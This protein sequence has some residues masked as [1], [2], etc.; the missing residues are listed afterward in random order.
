MRFTSEQQDAITAMRPLVCVSAGAGS[1]KTT[2]LVERI[3]HLLGAPALW[4][5]EEPQLERIAAITF[6][7][8]AAA[9]MK[10]RLR[11]KFRER[12]LQH[13]PAGMR[14]WRE[15]ER[16]VETARIST[17]HS[18]CASLLRE[19]ALHVGMDPDWS[20]LT[21]A[22]SACM[23]EQVIEETLHHLLEYEDP[24][25]SDLAV[26]LGFQ[27]LKRALTD[28][29]AE[30]WK[31]RYAD[32]ERLYDTPETLRAHWER[33][34]PPLHEQY[35]RMFQ[36]ARMIRNHF[37]ALEQYEGCCS[38]PSDKRE[39]QRAAYAALFR[40]LY[41]GADGLAEQ[42]ARV[43]DEFKCM[44]RSKKAWDEESFQG[45]G[46]AIKEARAFLQSE[47][48][49]PERDPDLELRAARLTCEFFRVGRAVA[50]AY[51][52]AR[53]AAAAID[54]DDMIAETQQLLRENEALRVHAARQFR[55]LLIDE[56]QDTDARQLEVA[57]L[58][59]GVDG[60]PDLF[61]VGDAK[62][63]IYLFRGAEVSLFRRELERD[64]KFI[65]LPVNYR[66]LPDV[67]FFVNDFFSKSEL[68][69]AVERYKPMEASRP[70]MNAPRVELFVPGEN[71]PGKR[72]LVEVTNVREAKFIAGRIREMCDP[73]APLLLPGN[74]PG[75][76]RPAVYADIV[77]LFRR[78]GNMHV[79][80]SALRE[81][82]I[83]YN[84]IAGEGF[85]QRRE[86]EDMIAL[87]KLIQDP[88]DEEMLLTALRS[89]LVPLSDES[90]MRLA[91]LPG[92]LA[93]AFHSDVVPE[94]FGETEMLEYAR[95]L[96]KRLYAAREM[97][98]GM[99][100]RRILD[101][102]HFEAVLLS[103]HLGVQH[104][105]NLRKLVQ[106]ADG[107]SQSRPVTLAEF[108]HYLGDMSVREIRE[109]EAALQSKK[110]G[111]VTLMTIHKSKGLEFPV[112]FL[113]EM[114][115]AGGA[116]KREIL[117]HHDALGIVVKTPDDAGKLE[118]N[119]AA[120]I[121]T[122]LHKQQDAAEAA[123]ILYVA[124]TRARD[125][126]VLCG[127]A[128]PQKG[129]WAETVNET[130]GLENRTHGDILT[131]DQWRAVIKRDVR[132]A[133][134][135]SENTEVAEEFDIETIRKN[136]QPVESLHGEVGAISVSRLLALMAAAP[137][138]DADIEPE[139]PEKESE[140]EE[141]T[142]IGPERETVMA[143][144]TLAHRMF[145]LWNFKQDVLP[146]LDGL[147]NEAGLGLAQ[148]EKNKK[149]LEGMAARFRGSSVMARFA[150]AE[151]VLRETPFVLNLDGV[152][153]YGVIDALIDD[154]LIVDYKTGRRSPELER[155]YEDQLLLYA[156]ALRAIKGKAPGQAMLWYADL[157]EA[158][159][160]E[161]T[162]DSI[163]AVLARAR[164]AVEGAQLPTRT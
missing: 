116:A 38:D 114:W 19:Y 109:G 11:R 90:L 149:D 6:T 50:D 34:A 13:D 39:Q 8:K 86:I 95:A 138:D 153:V 135:A 45:V 16:Q 59:A 117:Y 123:R 15:M 132:E 124:M 54:F 112:V 51:A 12:S 89:P 18:F 1:G 98:P 134:P 60:G 2:I 5:G 81:A 82:R 127:H 106:I 164:A 66:S 14:F 103:R 65:T 101:E 84:R 161:I 9:E 107:F 7:D 110:M 158:R 74:E 24:A 23:T 91:M 4:K 83:P 40:D 163:D 42:V 129:S 85:F 118:R 104:V 75:D 141:A 139:S 99:L 41:N 159:R 64:K 80:E 49:M 33:H 48:V 94:P 108:T 56:F 30:R 152:L 93:A 146:D 128:R 73:A 102:T 79:Y 88:W 105:S 145:E 47:C 143:R 22:E 133:P 69:S 71:T 126:L 62:Q 92:G 20:A 131:G 43:L 144:G 156:A 100:L 160:I 63:S 119:V 37:H 76:V 72:E 113:P 78:G 21:D 121:I 125:Y 154:A 96:F 136:M 140:T 32:I 17:I 52:A 26:T 3:A 157:G 27:G 35:L 148:R 162:N 61:I 70:A 58:L 25:A 137:L 115:V 151:S 46:E 147:L 10:A 130:Y 67:F 122:R 44:A 150:R 77:L 87:L 97:P 68:L 28:V 31:F 142:I 55:F 155:H 36:G 120:E 111:A 57:H 29:L 53:L